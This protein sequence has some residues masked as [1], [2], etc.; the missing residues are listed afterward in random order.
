MDILHLLLCLQLVSCGYFV[1]F[2]STPINSVLFLILTFCNA[3][4]ILFIFSAEFLGLIL[5]IV[6][7]GAVAVLFLFVIMMID[8]KIQHKS[9]K[10]IIR[11]FFE[12]NLIITLLLILISFEFLNSTNILF[13]L[14][15]FD[16]LFSLES[17]NNIDLLGQVLY[18]YYLVCVLIAGFILLVALVG[19]IVLTLRFNSVNTHQ[20]TFRQLA[21]TDSFISFFK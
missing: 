7:V 11:L 2:S 20:L 8:V 14:E 21:R 18:N 16:S 6:Y 4:G 13:S 10:S 19:A 3:A 9:E 15:S 12:Q 17:L 5:I 1:G